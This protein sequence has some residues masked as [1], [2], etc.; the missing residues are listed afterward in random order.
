[1]HRIWVGTDETGDFPWRTS[2][3]EAPPV[4]LA[5]W[6]L[7]GATE[8]DAEAVALIGEIARSCARQPAT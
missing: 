4:G 3:E 5:E 8:S 1:M 7:V 6:K 2:D